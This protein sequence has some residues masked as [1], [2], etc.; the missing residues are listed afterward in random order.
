M[1]EGEQRLSGSQIGD[2]ERVTRSYG[3]RPYR[4]VSSEHLRSYTLILHLSPPLRP[5]DSGL[6]LSSVT[7]E[8]HDG[9]SATRPTFQ[10]VDVPQYALSLEK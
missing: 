6:P 10:E 7:F 2:T 1:S 9:L 3:S 5:Y 8:V 4:S